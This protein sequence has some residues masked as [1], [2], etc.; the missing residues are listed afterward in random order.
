MPTQSL[1]ENGQLGLH[2]IPNKLVI[3]VIVAVDQA[4]ASQ[5]ASASVRRLTVSGCIDRNAIGR[6]FLQEER[7]AEG[8][9]CYQIHAPAKDAFERFRQIIIAVGDAGLI[10]SPKPDD[11]VNVAFF[12]VEISPHSR[13]K[14]FQALHGEALARRHHF[15]TVRLEDPVH[16]IY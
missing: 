2:H 1:C 14:H 12:R 3:Y 9:F 15:L 11:Q 5:P 8:A 6:D 7:T 16:F 10:G 13:A 4:I